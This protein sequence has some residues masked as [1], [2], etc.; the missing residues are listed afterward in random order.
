[1]KLPEPLDKLSQ[2]KHAK[3][4]GILLTFIINILLLIIAVFIGATAGY[5]LMMIGLVSV[6]FII[7]YL[8]GWRE[9]KMLL[10][11]GVGMFLAVGAINGPIVVHDAYSGDQ[12]P[13]VTSNI[14]LNWYTRAYEELENGT[15]FYDV[16]YK[17][18]DGTVDVYRAEPGSQFNFTVNVVCDEMPLETPIV[19]LGY[20]KGIW[21]V[22]ATPNMNETDPSDQNYADGKEFYYTMSL[23][24]AGIY[25]YWY[26]IVFGSGNELNSVNTT[27]ALGPL[28]GSELD[29]W[30]LY[31]PIGAASMFCNIGL[32][33]LIVVLLYWWLK[34]AKE[35]R[36]TWDEA[37]REKEDEDGKKD[38]GTATDDAL[39]E[40][41]PFT[42][43]Q[44]GAGVGEDDNFCPKCGER[45]DGVEDEPKKGGKS[46]TDPP[47]DSR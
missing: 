3:I 25:S 38:D 37:L 10:V 26:A 5:Y 22:V 44:C 32:L 20:A 45:F 29:N 17:L 35:K 18:Q 9:G 23:E 12:E 11:I 40:K 14:H 19:Q 27:V 41:K 4:I 43:D 8:F 31:I 7:P 46:K 1:M 16:S 30:A 21:G 2:M 6:T 39:D 42:C 28:V 33:F 24:D 36:R 34:V 47:E 15:Y 13:P